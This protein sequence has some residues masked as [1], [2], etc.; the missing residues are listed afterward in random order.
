MIPKISV[1]HD[2]DKAMAVYP[3]QQKQVRFAAA[4]TLTKVAQVAR[5]DQYEQ[6][7]RVFD[8][9]TRFTLNSLFLKRATP[10]DLEAVVYLKDTNGPNGH[11]LLP[12]IRGGSRVPKPFELALQR[13]GVLP[14]GYVAVPA[15]GARI[16]AYGNMERGQIIQVLSFLQSFAEQGY[17]ANATPEKRKRLARGSKKR[18]GFAYFVSG[19]EKGK[20]L[21]LGIW[22]RTHF[23]MGTA[24][25]P[26]L[27]FY[28]RVHYRA[29][30]E[31]AQGAHRTFEREWPKTYR[32]ELTNALLTAK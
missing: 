7:R 14:N 5:E 26:V 18:Q 19:R 27:L 3:R 25:R 24:I 21:P 30:Y 4:V 20:R 9:P 22:Q 28:R 29:V 12:Q 10:N 32:T 23:G 2:L 1:K 15:S 13:S 16:D 31:F 11:Y 17:A 6:M 8:R